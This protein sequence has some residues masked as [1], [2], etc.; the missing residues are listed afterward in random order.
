MK[1]RNTPA[2]DAVVVGSGPGGATVARELSLAGK[3]VLILEWGDNAPVKGTIGQAIRMAAIP[4]RSVLFT[5]ELLGLARGITTGGSS[6]FYYATAFRPQLDMFRSRGIDLSHEMEETWQELPV[7]PL[8]DE[9]IG[10][11]ARRVMESAGELG[12]N[13]KKLD[14]IIFQK[15]CRPECDKCVMGC[16]YDAK[17]NARE[18][19]EEAVGSGAVLLTGARVGRVLV[20]GR[21]AVGVEYKK[22]GASRQAYASSIVISA[23]GLGT[24][25]ILRASG[26]RAAGYDFFFDPLIGVFGTVGDI[27]DGK[28]FPMA[29]G[30]HLEDEGYLM[31]D[32][33][34]AGWL[35]LLFTA[36]VLRFD[37]LF[38]HARTLQIMIKVKD[39]LGG[40]LTDTGGVRKKL[41]EEEKK[42]FKRGYERAKKILENAG[43]RNIF[44]SWYVATHPG[45]T[46]KIGDVVDAD[47]KTEFDDL[48]V[49]DCSVIP[50]AWGLPPVL[51]LIALGKR[52]AKHLSATTRK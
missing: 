45:G 7:A 11:L 39:T 27:K 12:Y 22:D 48:Y 20:E 34:W 31:T 10:P 47:L 8:R 30:V 19:V 9:L 32:L 1:E 23:G 28:E 3:K 6:V 13:W 26:I 5:N 24:P 21:K 25:V 40:S 43:A 49:C 29:S 17:W 2:F 4:G 51:T 35:Y 50:E 15:K 46:A 33:G 44:R 41:S 37:R 38:S 14:K 18:F 36:E 52:L 42:K 16:P